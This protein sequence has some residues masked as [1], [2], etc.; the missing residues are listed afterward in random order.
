[1]AIFQIFTMALGCLGEPAPS[2]TAFKLEELIRS[3]PEN[4]AMTGMVPPAWKDIFEALGAGEGAMGPG[5]LE[6]MMMEVGVNDVGAY[7]DP[8]LKEELNTETV[9][10]KIQQIA[11]DK[12][13][14]LKIVHG[15]PMVQQARVEYGNEFS[16][17][18][19][20]INKLAGFFVKIENSFK[21]RNIH[22][23][24]GF[25][26]SLLTCFFSE[27][28]P[29]NRPSLGALPKIPDRRFCRFQVLG[30]DPSLAHLIN[31][32][33]LE[34]ILSSEVLH[35]VQD[36]T[37]DEAT[38]QDILEI[39]PPTTSTETTSTRGSGGSERWLPEMLDPNTAPALYLEG[40]LMIK[41]V[42]PGDGRHFPQD[43]DML[44]VDYVGYLPTGEVTR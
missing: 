19:F 15:N 20:A 34:K 31:P 37:L 18:R 23:I 28:R 42:K 30:Q 14:L 11:E 4:G 5:K 2:F 21:H 9:K 16:D 6:K 32:T 1:M 8:M 22:I 24:P 17:G 36:G 41:E 26:F 44:L 13:M 29:K 10:E 25:E 40:G 7:M 3:S 35:K 33:T 38:L 39:P 12:E 27:P 43:G